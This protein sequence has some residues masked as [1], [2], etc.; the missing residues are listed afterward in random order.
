MLLFVRHQMVDRPLLGARTRTLATGAAFDLI[1][2]ADQAPQGSTILDRRQVT[3][4]RDLGARLI[5]LRRQGKNVALVV[6]R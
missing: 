2:A 5:D 1:T 6:E 4:C 3:T